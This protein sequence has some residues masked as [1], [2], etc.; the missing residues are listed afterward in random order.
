MNLVDPNKLKQT[1]PKLK[2]AFL[3]N[4]IIKSSTMRHEQV[5]YLL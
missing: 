3:S 2:F 1:F 4:Y 5:Y